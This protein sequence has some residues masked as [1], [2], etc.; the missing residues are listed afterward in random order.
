MDDTYVSPRRLKIAVTEMISQDSQ[1]I[2][3]SQ[4]AVGG[5]FEKFLLQRVSR[6]VASC[7]S[8]KFRPG[9]RT[10]F[11]F[12]KFFPSDPHQPTPLRMLSFSSQSGVDSVAL[13]N[14]SEFS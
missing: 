2:V 6:C 7:V 5:I 13:L 8:A 4:Y 10:E 1:A 11:L 9:Y 14:S 12:L 3:A